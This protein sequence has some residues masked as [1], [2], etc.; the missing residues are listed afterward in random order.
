MT[1]NAIIWRLCNED[2]A[3]PLFEHYV[4]VMKQYMNQQI[5][6]NITE[7]ENDSKE[8]LACYVKEWDNFSL[9]LFLMNKLFDNVNQFHLRHL[10]G[11]P[12]SMTMTSL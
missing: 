6:Q 4:H 10:A 1:V 9:F 12:Q 5:I 7:R 8:F 3:E 11:T 2:E